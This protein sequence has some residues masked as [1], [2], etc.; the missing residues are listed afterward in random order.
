MFKL[1]RKI[2]ML[3]RWFA[4]HSCPEHDFSPIA[5]GDVR[6]K[7]TVTLELCKGC[8]CIRAEEKGKK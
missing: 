6:I 7:E 1:R 2:C 8:L 5:I 3:F 4:V